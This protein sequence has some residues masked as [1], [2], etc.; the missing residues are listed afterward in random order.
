MADIWENLNRDLGIER[1][2]NYLR[3]ERIMLHSSEVTVDNFSK[4]SLVKTKQKHIFTCQ[5]KTEAS[6]FILS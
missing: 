4:Y 5:N 2:T 3:K 6:Y 1:F